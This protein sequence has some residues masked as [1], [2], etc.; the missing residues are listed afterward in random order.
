VVL[1]TVDDRVLRVTTNTGRPPAKTDEFY[2]IRR[3]RARS[4]PLGVVEMVL[5]VC[6]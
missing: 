2:L 6:H 4:A 1:V 3:G 5:R